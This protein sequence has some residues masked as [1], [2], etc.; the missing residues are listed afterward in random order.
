MIGSDDGDDTKVPSSRNIPIV[1]S[2]LK[3]ISK[4]ISK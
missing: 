2:D 3:S 1:T 4:T